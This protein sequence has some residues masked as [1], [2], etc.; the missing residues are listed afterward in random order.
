MLIADT[1][2]AL[3]TAVL[4]YLVWAGNLQ[5]WQIYLL[6]LVRSTAGAFH[7]PAMLSSTSLMVPEE[8][9]HAGTGLKPA[10][11]GID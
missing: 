6:M 4:I 3:A 1:T 2:T 8:Q 10:L 9:T 5:T 7:M 11:A